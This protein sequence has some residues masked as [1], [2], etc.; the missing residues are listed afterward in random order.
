[1]E[2]EQS[3]FLQPQ[4]GIKI[5]TLNTW[6][7]LNGK[8]R[9]Q[10]GVLESRAN[11]MQRLNDQVKL[12]RQLSADILLLQEVNPLPFR[13]HWYA[14]QL[15]KKEFNVT[16]NSGVKLGWGPPYNLNEGL[17]ILIPKGWKCEFLGKLKLSGQFQ[18]SPFRLSQIK[19]PYLS[20][21]LHEARVATALR[22]WIPQDRASQNPEQTN[23]L[24][25][26]TAH[27]HHPPSLSASNAK[28]WETEI[29]PNLNDE[30]RAHLERAFRKSNSRRTKEMDSLGIWLASLRKA[31]EPMILGGDFNC[32]QASDPYKCLQR[33]GWTDLWN[34]QAHHQPDLTWDPSQNALAAKSMNFHFK[35]GDFNER[36]ESALHWLDFSPRRIDYLFAHPASELADVRA[37]T[38][39]GA[40][41]RLSNVQRFG[42]PEEEGSRM[43]PSASNAID[44]CTVGFSQAPIS[45]HYGV[46]AQFQML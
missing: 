14:T 33:K 41:G 9:F 39:F 4:T 30:E 2:T 16:C 44:S 32:E 22:I 23:S 28:L 21:Q 3:P 20:L 10:F 25:L 8:G 45:D 34:L 42:A 19:S 36:V 40:L 43:L 17:C 11:R 15:D 35:A 37:E 24:I 6:N 5:A 18:F 38:P 7:G 31:G 29:R 46:V 12:L 27:L 1:M 26:A 13:A